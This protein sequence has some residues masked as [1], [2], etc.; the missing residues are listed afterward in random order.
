[1]TDKA[2]GESSKGYRPAGIGRGYQ[3]NAG[4]I[5]P[6]PPTGGSAVSNQPIPQPNSAPAPRK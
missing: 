3:P 6:K 4:P 1:M 2:T 5:A